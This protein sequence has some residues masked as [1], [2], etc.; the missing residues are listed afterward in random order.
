MKI[1]RGVKIVLIFMVLLLISACTKSE[2]MPVTKENILRYL[3]KVEKAVESITAKEAGQAKGGDEKKQAE[4]VRK[5]FVKPIEDMGYN[6][7]KTVN[8]IAT[9]L[10]DKDY[11]ATDFEMQGLMVGFMQFVPRKSNFISQ[12]TKAVLERLKRTTGY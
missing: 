12:E 3:K 2:P 4:I 6:Y 8:L 1:Q 9:K 11:S 10:I 5:M 7:D